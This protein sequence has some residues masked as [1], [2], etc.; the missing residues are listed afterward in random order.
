MI[1]CIYN[2]THIY[3]SL[4][5]HDGSLRMLTASLSLVEHGHINM[6]DSIQVV[7]LTVEGNTTWSI[8]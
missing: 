1:I 2:N 5:R 4:K 3:L 7:L 6:V 8:L